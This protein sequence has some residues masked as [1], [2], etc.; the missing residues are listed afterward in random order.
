MGDRVRDL[1]G[2]CLVIWL[3]MKSQPGSLRFHCSGG[4][5]FHPVC[6]SDS[7]WASLSSVTCPLEVVRMWG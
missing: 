1:E 5:D 2:N 4:Y 7:P 6:A 3:N